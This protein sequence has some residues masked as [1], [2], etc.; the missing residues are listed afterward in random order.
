MVGE[1]PFS[2]RGNG[3]QL[4]QPTPSDDEGMSRA[5]QVLL[6]GEISN[7]R[8][9]MR[10]SNYVFLVTIQ[11]QGQNLRAIYKPRRGEAPLWDFPDGTLYKR[12]R[13]AYLVSQR[14]KWRLI[15]PTVIREGPYGIGAEQWFISNTNGINYDSFFNDHVRE[16]Q[17]VA[18]FDWLTNNADRKIGHCLESE[19]KKL[20]CVDHGLTFNTVP[21]LRTV[22]WDF[23]G[24]PIPGEIIADLNTFQ[25]VLNNDLQFRQ[26]LLELLYPDEV[27]AL[28]LRLKRILKN[29]VFPN[30]TGSFHDIPWPP[31]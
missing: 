26:N 22:I 27:D 13:A 8:A 12:E 25:D 18:A 23:A 20:W 15:P 1:K 7:C 14:L 2:V 28:K 17:Q 31:Y 24:E 29:P 10:A 30:S 6:E 16:F 21:K 9:L 4:Q 19:D 11:H 3:K 5:C